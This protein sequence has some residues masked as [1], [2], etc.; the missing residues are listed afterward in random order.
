M[1]Q[2]YPPGT[3]M[4]VY[5]LLTLYYSDSQENFKLHSLQFCKQITFLRH[6][7]NPTCS[8][9]TEHFSHAILKKKNPQSLLGLLCPIPHLSIKADA[10]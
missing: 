9:R 3:Y 7:E 5:A 8:I 4:T 1:S 2:K 10:P 6:S